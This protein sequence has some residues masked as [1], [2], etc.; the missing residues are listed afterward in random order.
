MA[1][2]VL[3]DEAVEGVLE[4]LETEDGCSFISALL[5]EHI[6]RFGARCPEEMK[7]ESV[8]I[9]EDHTSLISVIKAA[10]ADR[11]TFEAPAAKSGTQTGVESVVTRTVR[12]GLSRFR[13]RFVVW[14]LRHARQAIRDR[15]NQRFR[16]AQIYDVVRR[17]VRTV[18][19]RWV[20]LGILNERD[21]IFFLELGEIEAYARGTSTTRDL[22]PVIRHRRDEYNRNRSIELPRHFVTDAEASAA[23][24]DPID[25]TIDGTKPA[26]N[27][28]S[29]ITGTSCFP[30]VVEADA[31]VLD[32]FRPD[33]SL[34]GKI[35]VA[36][37]T[38]PGWT[39]LFTGLSGL[40]VERGSV[41]SHTAIVAREMGIPCIV[42]TT[43]ATV[44]F[45]TGDRLIL[46]AD[47]GWVERIDD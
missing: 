25:R 6:R 21:D 47:D 29:R 39:V 15:E 5:R 12:A 19:D 31:V 43:D 34:E 42:G 26:P 45:S 18:G 32:R 13:F 38:D 1:I 41:L 30:G 20:R 36:R 3:E 33:I 28:G 40:V 14:A 22:M 23:A 7:I 46:D 10:V 4:K 35:L 24:I 16:R 11:R 9:R 17:I 2:R 37:S 27:R 44:F 8:S